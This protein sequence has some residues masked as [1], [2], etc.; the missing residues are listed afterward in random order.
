MRSIKAGRRDGLLRVAVAGGV[1]VAVGWG[2]AEACL[3]DAGD[4]VR[5]T[6]AAPALAAAPPHA[7]VPVAGPSGGTTTPKT[8]ART[9]PRRQHRAGPS[10]TA[11]TAPAPT[12]TRST[13]ATRAKP[14]PT[15]T[16]ARPV[17]PTTPPATS[18]RGLNA[19]EAHVLTLVN[20]ERAKAGCHALTV[21]PILVSVA[22]AHS[23]DMAARG[24]FDHT[25]PD[26]M[27]PFDR[28]RQAGYWGGLMGE[29]IAAGQPTPQAVMQAW[30]NSPGHRANIL[31]C[32]YTAIG[33]GV[34]TRPGSPFRIYW[35]QDFGDR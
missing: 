28:M 1:L 25:S 34:F 5:T 31:N 9:T 7:S 8:T 32:G 22:R 6:S 35:T 17:P 3:R 24:Y 4:T 15:A 21:N 23:Q 18:S 12:P 27:S 14:A 33:I 19:D 20:A 26:G 29:N 16:T 2:T 10:P 13:P 11:T 30:M